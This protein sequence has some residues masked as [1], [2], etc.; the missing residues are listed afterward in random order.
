MFNIFSFLFKIHADRAIYRNVSFYTFI[1]I[2]PVFSILFSIPLI[3]DEVEGFCWSSKCYS[4]F[5][6]I[7]N[8]P[9]LLSSGSIILGVTYIRLYNSLLAS[10]KLAM[11]KREEVYKRYYDHLDRIHYLGDNYIQHRRDF[12][13][14]FSVVT[15]DSYGFYRAYFKKNSPSTTFS[16]ETSIDS[17]QEACTSISKYIYFWG[18]SLDDYQK[19]ALDTSKTVDERKQ[20]TFVYQE[21]FFGILESIFSLCYLKVDLIK[22]VQLDLTHFK[23]LLLESIVFLE[24]MFVSLNIDRDDQK[25]YLLRVDLENKVDSYN[26]IYEELKILRSRLS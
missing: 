1:L 26:A 16:F 12:S 22:G 11:D 14:Y 7:F 23:S 5:V 18:N 3:F 2:L 10:D 4:N 9:L 17:M 24:T 15:F 21:Q 8:F 25:F 19:R 20:M 13:K 6:E